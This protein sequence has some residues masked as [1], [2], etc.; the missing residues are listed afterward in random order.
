M[1]SITVHELT[2]AYALDALDSAEAR[3]YE[4]HLATCAEC[5]AELARL[6]EPAGALAFAVE[7]PEPPLEL[8]ERILDAARSERSNV[9]PLR[10]RWALP[11]VAVAAVAACAAIG[12]G[13]WAGS[14][15]RS[16]DRERSASSRANH[17]LSILSDP[18]ASR[19]RLSGEASGSLVVS[20]HGEAAIVVSR[21]RPAPAGKTYEAWVIQNGMP[22][23]AGTFQSGGDTSVLAL[24]HA[25]PNG[26]KV[27]VTLEPKPGGDQPTGPIVVASNAV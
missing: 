23:R 18:S 11:V 8:R 17:A 9:V 2:A 27:A 24:A 12:F 25:V 21:L 19:H 6:S 16:L 26:A 13:I 4:G 20:P 14:L 22:V 1:E 10:P 7:S 15:S 5:R 3:E